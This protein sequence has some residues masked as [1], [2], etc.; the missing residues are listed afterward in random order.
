[1]KHS[2]ARGDVGGT[3]VGVTGILRNQDAYQRWIRTT[4]VRTKYYQTT[5]AMADNFFITDNYV[6]LISNEL[7]NRLTLHFMQLV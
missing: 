5:L 7:I 1:M 4:H 2:K 3:G 6:L